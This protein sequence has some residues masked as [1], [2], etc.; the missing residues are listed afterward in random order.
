[1]RFSAAFY[2]AWLDRCLDA[3]AP[4]S[5]A[6]CGG[7]RAGPPPFCLTCG[8]PAPLIPATLGGV[9]LVAAG[10]YQPPLSLAVRRL[11]FDGCSELARGL[12]L[13][14][15]PRLAH[16]GLDRACFVPVPL[17]R[18]RL[19]ERG[20][21]QSALIARCLARATGGRVSVRTLER[22]RA[23]DQ[24]ARLGR[25]ARRDNVEDAF[26]VRQGTAPAESVLVDD[27]VTT[28]ATALACLEALRKAG[29]E[30][31]AVVALARAEGTG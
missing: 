2:G 5:C 22:H 14:L 10:R 13:L 18:A 3:F 6:A 15:A 12:A 16:L 9:P 28:G 20:Y 17:H 24:Q 21:N 29:S 26:R 25:D 7:P 1:M 31:R 8:E 23:T 19:V 30:V 11:K 4:P 27:V